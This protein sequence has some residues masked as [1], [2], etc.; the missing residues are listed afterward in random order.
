MKLLFLIFT[1]ILF[2]EHTNARQ[3]VHPNGTLKINKTATLIAAQDIIKGLTLEA[4]LDKCLVQIKFAIT[5]QVKEIRFGNAFRS[6]N[7]TTNRQ[8]R[9]DMLM[10]ILDDNDILNTT[11]IDNI[12]EFTC[13]NE[14][15]C[16]RRFVL[17]QLKWLF[18]ANYDDI[19]STIRP[20]I[21]SEDDKTGKIDA[22]LS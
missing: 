15:G 9:V 11:Y 8:V 14:D 10:N 13:D 18:E 22:E 1:L 12:V 17:G 21:T 19:E 20:L 2:N 16:D 5:K 4:S 6:N 3:C 7:L